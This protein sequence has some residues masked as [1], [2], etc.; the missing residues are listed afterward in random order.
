MFR[1][2]IDYVGFVCL[3]IQ[4]P[5]G[6]SPASGDSSITIVYMSE[7]LWELESELNNN[8]T[9]ARNEDYLFGRSWRRLESGS[10]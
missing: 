1:K 2:G 9:L 10:W 3:L 6:E 4:L 8:N 7:K 5:L